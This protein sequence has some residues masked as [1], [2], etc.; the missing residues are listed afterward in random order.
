VGSFIVDIL[1]LVFVRDKTRFQRLLGRILSVA[2]TSRRPEVI[3]HGGVGCNPRARLRHVPH[4]CN[5]LLGGAP[6]AITD[7]LQR[8][9]NAAARLLSGTKKFDRGLS[10]LMHVGVWIGSPAAEIWPFAYVWR[11]WNPYFRGRGGRRGLAMAPLE[12]AMVVSY[13]PSIVTVALSVTTRP[14]FAIECRRRSNQQGAGHFGP[15]FSDV[16]LGLHPSCWGCKE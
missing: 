2:S 13:R 8:L 7:K 11:I 3:G 16:P 10:Q 5:V 1:Q 4:R 12:R 9:L 15:K 14:Q 6:K